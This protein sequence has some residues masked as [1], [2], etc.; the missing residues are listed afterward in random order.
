MHSNCNAFADY[1]YKALK[2]LP[3]S[4]RWG[5]ADNRPESRVALGS[6]TQKPLADHS[7]KFADYSF[8]DSCGGY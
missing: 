8:F 3:M 2:S 6:E 1:S 4:N 7:F 5:R